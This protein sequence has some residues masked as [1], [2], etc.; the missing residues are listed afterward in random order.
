VFVKQAPEFIKCL[1]PA[2]PLSSARAALESAALRVH[3]SLV[4]SHV[5]R[6]LHFDPAR[7]TLVLE[8]LH[9]HT[10]LR[11]ELIL[12]R[13]YAADAAALGV[14]MA[15]THARTWRGDGADSA[16]GPGGVAY[17]ARFENALL[18]D[19]TSEY[20]FRKPYELA[21]PSNRHA[22]ALDD[23]VAPLRAAG[24]AAAGAAAA[25]ERRF[26]GCKQCLI[27]GDLHA[28]SVMVLRSDAAAAPA[29]PSAEPPP[30][31]YAAGRL[32]VIDPE[33]AC[34]GPAAFDLGMALAAYALA[35]GRHV[36]LGFGEA[37]RAVERAIRAMCAAY[38]AQLAEL[39]PT[40][41]TAAGSREA[42]ADAHLALLREATG[43][44]GAELTRRVIGA[45]HAPELD[46][47]DDE[48]ARAA[49]ER[50][51]LACGVRALMSWGDVRGIDDVLA[52]LTAD[53]AD[54]GSLASPPPS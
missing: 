23:A 16:G 40:A 29:A 15:R 31:A 30:A 27:H 21:E 10:L 35:H 53:L 11:D 44:M 43:F 20:V 39:R 7:A 26:R 18:C 46:G 49:A 47:I 33:F 2:A 25:L 12:G 32:R 8:D 37:V 14:F 34:V 1:G 19:I 36:T 24:S 45:A 42:D 38:A 41:D 4:P 50:A 17:S 52:I 54:R 22:P 3:N 51:T 9:S 6:H 5:P 13:I 28:G 48:G